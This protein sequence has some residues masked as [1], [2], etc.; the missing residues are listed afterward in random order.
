MV[1]VIPLDDTMR[2]KLNAACAC[3]PKVEY[4]DPVDGEV[5]SNGPIITHNAQDGRE[6]FEYY[7]FPSGKRWAHLRS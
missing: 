1:N 2:H 7:G 4:W 3:N 6:L 5:W